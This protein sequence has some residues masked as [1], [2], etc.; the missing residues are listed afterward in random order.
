MPTLTYRNSRGELVDVPV[1]P[2]TQLKNGLGGVLEQVMR[3]GAVAITRH[4]T[5]KAVL[6]AYDE[7]VALTRDR[8]PALNDLTAEYDVLLARMQTSQA[9]K[10]MAAAFNATPAELGRAAVKAARK[11]K[12]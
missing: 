2:S 6:I 10:A 7:F 12:R 9:R 3:G 4:E 11:S 5:P 1:V 8:A